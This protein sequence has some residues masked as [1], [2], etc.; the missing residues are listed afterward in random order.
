MPFFIG[1]EPEIASFVVGHKGH[2]STSPCTNCDILRPFKVEDVPSTGTV[3][4]VRG[5]K[6]LKSAYISAAF[7]PEATVV[8]FPD[9][10]YELRMLPKSYLVGAGRGMYPE[11]NPM[12]LVPGMNPFNNPPC[13][14]HSAD[15][16]VF[17]MI[18]D[19][20]VGVIES[21]PKNF[22]S[23]AVNGFDRRWPLVGRFPGVKIFWQGVSTLAKVTCHEHRH[24]AMSLPFVLNGGI[25]ATLP[26]HALPHNW[27]KIETML[28]KCA[29]L[30]M[31]WRTLLGADAS[32]DWDVYWL[33]EIG[34]DLVDAVG[35]VYAIIYGEPINNGSKYHKVV[36]WPEGVCEFGCSGGWNGEVFENQHICSCKRWRG[37]VS[38]RGWNAEKKLL[39]KTVVAEIHQHELRMD[40]NR[41]RTPN[42]GGNSV[43]SRPSSSTAAFSS[44]SARN[45]AKRPKTSASLADS[46]ATE[47]GTGSTTTGISDRPSGKYVRQ[48]AVKSRLF[49]VRGRLVRGKCPDPSDVILQRI[50][51]SVSQTGAVPDQMLCSTPENLWRDLSLSEYSKVWVSDADAWVGVGG[52]VSYKMRTSETIVDDCYGRVAFCGFMHHVGSF[53]VV[54]RFRLIPPPPE[55]VGTISRLTDFCGSPFDICPPDVPQPMGEEQVC[56]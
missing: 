4:K 42:R 13:R 52:D 29:C 16:G 6:R 14:M 12:F 32:H 47:A 48:V 56:L 43:L 26:L 34:C 44:M 11:F 17:V 53:C 45:K 38:F 50:C 46:A 21:A 40:E 19:M 20:T 18:L 22:K 7:G 35:D 27:V 25:T 23:G 54:R 8:T 10:D 2:Q 39:W 24:M 15:H 3:L 49:G 30:Y 5:M 36:H 1:D 51:V 28:T 41:S 33:E 9:S 31:S 37:K 55:F